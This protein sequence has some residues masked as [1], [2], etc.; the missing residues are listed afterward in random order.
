[1]DVYSTYE[2]KAR[3]SEILR[4]VRAGRRVVVTHHGT[5]V[6]EIR[7]IGVEPAR[8]DDRLAQLERDGIVRPAA[9]PGRPTPRAARRPGA[10]ARFLATRD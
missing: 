2:A 5:Q 1:M 6:A 10:L 8:L 9:H 7:P 3:F 4:K